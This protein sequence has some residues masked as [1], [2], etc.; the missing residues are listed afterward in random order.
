M[1]HQA[2]A[3]SETA[4]SAS[5]TERAK[6]DAAISAVHAKQL[7]FAR[8]P[9]DAKTRLLS[10]L[11]P[12]TLA[13]VDE[14]IREACKAK[15]L[16]ENTPLAGEEWLGGPLLLMRNIRLLVDT[17][18][19]IEQDGTPQL[20]KAVHTREDGRVVVDV[21]PSST[22]DKLLYQ[23]FSARDLLLPGITE[24]EARAKQ[25]SFY[26]TKDPEGGTTLVLGAGNVASIP[27]M[28]ALYKLFVEGRVCVIKMNPVNE[29]LGPFFEKAFAPLIA[30]DYV[31]RRLRGRRSGRVPLP[32]SR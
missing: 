17:M 3:M 19:Q 18:R 2:L 32:A 4:S 29:Y 21:F 26:K 27:P 10:D 20:G 6:L 30:E 14:W 11:I 24:E 25:A 13:N 8:L 5:Q 15:G 12:S 28:D 31:R 23:G 1:S 22:F 9:I 7:E 16:P